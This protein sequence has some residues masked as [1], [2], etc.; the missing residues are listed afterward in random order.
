MQDKLSDKEMNMLLSSEVFG[1]L[2]CCDDG[3]PYIVP[4]AYVYNENTLYG[5]TTEGKKVEK[6]RKNPLVCFQ[7]ESLKEGQW[8]SVIC[9][10]GY[11]KNWLS[12]NWKGRSRLKSSNS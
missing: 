1:H 4:M 12:R 3:K 5:Q 8:R 6:L 11:L 2:G 7:V 10:G 9:W